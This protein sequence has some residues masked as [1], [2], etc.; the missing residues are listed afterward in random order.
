MARLASVLALAG[1]ALAAPLGLLGCPSNA[2]F[3]E[4]CS[5]GNCRCSISSCGEGAA[6]DTKQRRCRCVK[7]YFDLAGQ[8]LDQRQ[9]NAYCGPGYS[10]APPAPGWGGGCVQLTCQAGDRLDLKTGWCIPKEQLAQQ[11]GVSLGKGETLGCKAGEALV[12]EGGA[13]ACVPADQSCAKDEYWTGQGCAKEPTC[14]TGQRFDRGQARC[15]AYASGGDELV[16]DVHTWAQS[17]FG[18]NGGSGT[19]SF[20]S[21]LAKKPLSFGLSSGSSTIV[22]VKVD[23]SFPSSEVARGV[24]QSN[25]VYDLSGN[26]VPPAGQ[27]EVASAVDASFRA[28]V[29]GG[30]RANAT[31]TSTTVKCGI[32]H[33]GKPIVVPESGGF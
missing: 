16:V 5:G 26:V 2:C 24:A 10:Y 32:V 27:Q 4:V 15:I 14:P 19:P 33:G 20:C 8:C 1:L 29:A 17:T 3:L 18:P 21:T 7:G 22:R 11:A 25:A 30:G 23:L 12:V 13:A 6:Y 9:A 28:L 31:Q